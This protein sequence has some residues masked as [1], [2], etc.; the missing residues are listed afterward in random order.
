MQVISGG[1][2]ETTASFAATGSTAAPGGVTAVSAV[3]GIANYTMLVLRNVP[4]QY[5]LTFG[6]RY[7]KG[8]G[9]S[10]RYPGSTN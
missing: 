5:N 3:A 8:A 1:S 7:M 2:S 4:G 9:C 6:E 10:G